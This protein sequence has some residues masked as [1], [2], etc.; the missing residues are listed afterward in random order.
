MARVT[1]K[2]DIVGIMWY[3]FR[4]IFFGSMK[5]FLNPQMIAKSLAYLDHGLVHLHCTII[6]V[7]LPQGQVAYS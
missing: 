5:S 7:T 6:L 1:Q 4:S 2:K 3:F